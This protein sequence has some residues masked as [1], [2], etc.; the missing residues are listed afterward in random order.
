MKVA[1]YQVLGWRSEKSEPSRMGRSTAAYT[2]EAERERSEAERFYRPWP[3]KLAGRTSL[4]C[5]ISQHFVLGY[6]N[7]VPP[8]RCLPRTSSGWRR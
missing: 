6:F 1:Q 5:V 8:G 2:L 7:W 3:R 4:F